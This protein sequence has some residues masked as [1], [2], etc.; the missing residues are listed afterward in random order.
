M[1]TADTARLPVPGRVP[2]ATA[3]AR[4]IGVALALALLAAGGLALREA[5]VALGWMAGT[6][7]I[8]TGI[9]AVDGLR[10]QWWMIPAGAVVLAVGTWMVFCALRPR[11]KTAVA[12]DAQGAVWMRPRDVARLASHAAAAVPGVEVLRSEATRRKVILY[13]GL[14]GAEPDSGAKGAIAAAVGSATEILSPPPQIA[15]RIG[16]S[17]SS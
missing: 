10:S 1:T 17:G 5:G 12:V 13:V 2:V 3:P 6:S 4:Y 7:W 11:R 14:T 16:T 9:T 15:V 8:G